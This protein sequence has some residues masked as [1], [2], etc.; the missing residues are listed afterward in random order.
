M[1]L[2][3]FGGGESTPFPVREGDSVFLSPPPSVSFP[4]PEVSEGFCTLSSSHPKAQIRTWVDSS[5]W[6]QESRVRL[7]VWDGRLQSPDP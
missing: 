1:L 2:E 5:I 3:G 7:P 6:E 4:R